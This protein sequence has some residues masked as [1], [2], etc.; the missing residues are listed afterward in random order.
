MLVAALS[1]DWGCYRTP[2]GKAVYFTL[3][4]EAAAGRPARSFA[5]VPSSS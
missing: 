2:A 1:S 5:P 3:T 4:F